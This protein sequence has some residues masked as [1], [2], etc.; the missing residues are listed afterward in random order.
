M[1][2][3]LHRLHLWVGIPAGLMLLIFSVTGIL[4]LLPSLTS[5]TLIS[6]AWMPVR[7]QITDWNNGALRGDCDGLLYGSCGVWTEQGTSA[8]LDGHNVLALARGADERYYAVTP[9]RLWVGSPGNW[10]PVALPESDRW[11]WIARDEERLL[12]TGYHRVLSAAP[13]YSDWQQVSPAPPQEPV[14]LP[15]LVKKLHS[16]LLFGGIGG[17]VV[18]VLA[19]FLAVLSGSGLLH[20]ALKRRPNRKKYVELFR[21]N[22]KLHFHIGKIFLVLLLLICLSGA[23]LRPPLRPLIADITMDATAEFQQCCRD[24]AE[25]DYLLVTRGGFYRLPSLG[26]RLSQLESAPPTGRKGLTVLQQQDDGAWLVGS[27]K[28]LFRWVRSTGELSLLAEGN[29]AGYTALTGAVDAKRGTQ[30]LP[31]PPELATAPISLRSIAMELHS[32]RLF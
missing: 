18:I 31:Q 6:R 32:G 7:Y 21:N 15:A 11:C 23:L 16:R 13:P 19:L 10:Q 14:A 29:I 4:L 3:F 22:L 12:L 9:T 20:V 30:L 24:R 1:K 17:A 25:G 28:G 5:E 2:P 27:E 26:A 8:G